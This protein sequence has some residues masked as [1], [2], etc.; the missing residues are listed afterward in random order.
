MLFDVQR[1]NMVLQACRGVAYLHSMKV[2]HRDL[3]CRNLLVSNDFVVK[4]ADFG[5]RPC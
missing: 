5:I 4:L 3:A 2:L 1:I